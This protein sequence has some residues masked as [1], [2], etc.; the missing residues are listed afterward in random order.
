MNCINK[1]ESVPVNIGDFTVYCEKFKS[2]GVK[3]FS[4]QNTVSGNEIITNSGKKAVRITFSGRICN[5]NPLEF[6]VKINQMMYSTESFSIEYKETVFGKCH[7]QSFI[8]N[9]ENNGYISATVTLIATEISLKGVET[10]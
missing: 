6:L 5:K 1:K 4:E 10:S 2:S 7:L 8:V 9:D 3:N